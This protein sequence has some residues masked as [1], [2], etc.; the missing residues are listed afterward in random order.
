M[1]NHGLIRPDPG[2]NRL[3]TKKHPTILGL[4]FDPKL[5]FNEHIN[6]TGIKASKA[7]KVVKD[8]SG[9]NWGQQKETILHT[10]HTRHMQD[11]SWNM[12]AQYGHP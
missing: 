2:L 5:T 11:Q 6:Q 12:P 7:L 1:R 9:T 8:I 10:V 3:D 4:T